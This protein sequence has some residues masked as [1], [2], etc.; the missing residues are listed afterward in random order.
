MAKGNKSQSP[1]VLN[2]ENQEDFENRMTP[3]IKRSI[4][5]IIFQQKSIARDK[6]ALNEA[7]EATAEKLGIKKGV[8]SG[9]ITLIIKEEEQGGAVKSKTDD[10][11]FVEE[12]FSTNKD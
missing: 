9:R 3:E 1:N 6:E 4:E 5:D 10:I 11:N 7:I 8:L 12:Y 2:G